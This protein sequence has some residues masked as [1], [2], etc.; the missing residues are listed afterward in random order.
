MPRWGWM[1][2]AHIAGTTTHACSSIA[3]TYAGALSN[4]CVSRQTEQQGSCLC[5]RPFHV[6]RWNVGSRLI[7]RDVTAGVHFSAILLRI[8]IAAYGKIGKL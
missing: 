4:H 1:I 2:V 8:Y 3:K 7:R 5:N 6:K